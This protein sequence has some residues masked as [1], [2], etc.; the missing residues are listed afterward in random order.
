VTDTPTITPTDTPTDT[1]TETPTD[2][3]TATPTDTFLPGV[4][5]FTF[6]TTPTTT[7]TRTA[8][9]TPTITR[10]PTVT[11]TP[12]TTPTPSATPSQTPLTRR[13]NIIS[14]AQCTAAG[15]PYSCCTGAGLGS[16]NNSN[17]HLKS[18]LTTSIFISGHQDWQFAPPDVN[19]VRQ[20]T[21]PTSGTHFD[22]VSL[23]GL[24]AVCVRP[25]APGSGQI[26]C[27]GV[28]GTTNYNNTVDQDHNS[29]NGNDPGFDNDPGCT[30][31]F[32][33]PD[34][35][36]SSASLESATDPHPGVCN[37]PVHIV[38]SGTFP[39]G[40]MLL[41]ENLTLRIMTNSPCTG[42]GT[43]YSCCT[44]SGTGTCSS[45]SPNPCPADNT[46]FNAGAGDL[47]ASASVTT[48]TAVGTVHDA[49]NSTGTVLTDTVTGIP[50]DCGNIDA[51]VVND[52][53]LGGA[54]TALDLQPPTI[55]DAIASISLQCQ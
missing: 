11:N 40:G 41:Y 47:S 55:T 20:I 15:N 10:T 30:A 31:T 42:A 25:G 3:P 5:T 54:F 21:A 49:N 45:C 19:G 7:P 6:T 51:G 24:A 2:T 14:N 37:S 32:T 53:K 52:G 1:P 50:F 36:V 17:I 33:E 46:P 16:C 12:S 22:C 34:G 26:N 43:P 39:A 27:N 4:P 48:G 8:T 23:F 13:C 18:S 28:G 35:Q 29:N 38:E 9:N 44:G